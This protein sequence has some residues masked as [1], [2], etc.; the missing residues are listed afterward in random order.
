MLTETQFARLERRMLAATCD[1]VLIS[2]CCLAMYLAG[3]LYWLRNLGLVLLVTLAAVECLTGVSPG[4][5]LWG[6]NV[7]VEGQRWPR[8]RLMLRGL[9]RYLPVALFVFALF[10]TQH[11]GL[12]LTL[13]GIVGML[14]TVFIS[15]SYV[16]VIRRERTTF[17]LIAGTRLQ[18]SSERTTA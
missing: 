11:F 16:S 3:S 15:Q 18:A 12:R 10:G 4:K 7:S 1:G 14:A 2:A 13:L 9:A 17:D 5:W 8:L 6:W